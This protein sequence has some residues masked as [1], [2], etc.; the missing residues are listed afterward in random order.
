[1]V[2]LVPRWRGLLAAGDDGQF[3]ARAVALPRADY[4]RGQRAVERGHRLHGPP[5]SAEGKRRG[6]DAVDA[7]PQSEGSAKQLKE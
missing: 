1:M 7:H 5:Q 2:Q 4:G 6:G 3:C